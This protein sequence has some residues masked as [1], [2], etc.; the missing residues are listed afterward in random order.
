MRVVHNTA[1]LIVLYTVSVVSE[2]KPR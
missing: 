1:S 2:W